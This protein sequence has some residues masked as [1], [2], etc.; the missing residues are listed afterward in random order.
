MLSMAALA[1]GAFVAASVASFQPPGSTNAS[2]AADAVR[3]ALLTLNDET[4]A[5]NS[6]LA[7]YREGLLESEQL[8]A[9]TVRLNPTDTLSLE[10][11]AVVR[12]E[13]GV[14]RDPPDSASVS[15]LATIA[16]AR[17]PRVPDAQ[18][19]L[20]ELFLRMGRIEDAVKFMSVALELSPGKTNQ[21]VKS[22]LDAGV[23]AATIERELP[24]TVELVVALKEPYERSGD[25]ADW[26]TTAET[27]LPK[28]PYELI[29]LY[30]ESCLA[31]N[32]ANRLLEHAGSLGV[33]ADPN[34]EARRQIAIGRAQLSLRD[35]SGAVQASARGRVLAP[36]DTSVLDY[37][38]QIAMAAG[39]ASDAEACFREALHTLALARGREMDRARLYRLHGQALEYIGRI[40][41]AFDAYRRARDLW[42]DDP[43]LKQRFATSSPP[44]SQ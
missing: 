1:V 34:A 22:M 14:L 39:R 28:Y 24:R 30:A 8:L 12:W 44:P 15:A 23:D 42:P 26:L 20:G 6:R 25:R 3:R 18:F 32:S 9:Q 35:M 10:R 21:V 5:P 16:A 13:L 41:E 31:A 40:D 7:M 33:L 36:H 37:A 29:W 38:G 2:R 11:L 27:L 19:G 17:A 4:L 43:W